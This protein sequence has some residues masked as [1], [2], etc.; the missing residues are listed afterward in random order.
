[1]GL[2][3]KTTEFLTLASRGS[4][5]HLSIHEARKLLDKILIDKLPL[6]SEEN[7]IGE[8]LLVAKP[9]I[10]SELSQPSADLNFE[11]LNPHF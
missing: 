6:E 10:L 8:E 1:M 7:S 5:L 9:K 11:P 3:T 2:N 4:F